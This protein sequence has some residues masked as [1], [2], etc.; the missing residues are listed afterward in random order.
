MRPIKYVLGLVLV[1]FF[2]FG[3]SQEVVSKK[4]TIDEI[5]QLAL[6]NNQKLKVSKQSVAVAVQQTEVYKQYQLPDISFNAKAMYLGDVVLLDT[7]FSKVTTVDMPH[8]GNTFS[9]QAQQLIYKGNAINNTVKIGSLQEQLASLN[10]ENDVIGVKFL[11]ISNYLNLYKLYNQKQ[12]F[13]ENI[14][15]AQKRIDN[16]TSFYKQGMVTRNEIIRGD[17]LL[18]SLN[19][20]IVTIDNNIAI[21]NTQLAIALG[22]PENEQIIPDDKILK[23]DTALQDYGTYKEEV[24]TNHPLIKTIDLQK[25]LAQ[26][27]LDI[28]KSDKLPILA[29]F[30]AYNMQRPLTNSFPIQD[31]YNNNWQVGVSLTYNIESLYKTS[32]KESLDKLKIEQIS[33]VKT[34]TQQNLQVATKAAYLKYNETISQKDTYLES[35]RLAEEN[36]RITEKKYLNQLALITEMLD[37]SNSKLEAE[38][39]Y[40]NSEISIIYSYYNLL[41]TTGNL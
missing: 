22:L 39:Q 25:E 2:K 8:F 30:A 28:T 5:V 24:I 6:D 17:L 14:K 16:V 13:V 3:F 34:L 31:L 40:I 19:Q 38:L 33:E 29:G 1:L 7:D 18:A 9:L 15:L 26:T 37:A 21:L 10:V 36:Y 20:A 41:K 35:K 12:V 23:L 4:Y 32:K 11:V 27:S